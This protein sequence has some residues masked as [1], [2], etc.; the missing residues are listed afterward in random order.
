MEML[1]M[2][3]LGA[4]LATVL[5]SS[6]MAQSYQSEWGSGNIVPDTNQPPYGATVSEPYL[7]PLSARA[8]APESR[9]LSSRALSARSY[10]YQPAPR[11]HLHSHTMQGHSDMDRE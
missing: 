9:A 2:I 3:I 7:G 1:K 10:A 4:G 5:A 8:S 11:H 6:A